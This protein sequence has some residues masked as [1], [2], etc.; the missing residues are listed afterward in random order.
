MILHC[1]R[2]PVSYEVEQ[3]KKSP[4]LQQK[5]TMPKYNTG[6]LSTVSVSRRLKIYDKFLIQ[7]YLKN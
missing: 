6:F 2:N 7:F 5:Q 3:L 4:V 1:T